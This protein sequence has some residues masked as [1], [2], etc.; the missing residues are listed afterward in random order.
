MEM[1]RY[2]SVVHYVKAMGNGMTQEWTNDRVNA[3]ILEIARK[4]GLNFGTLKEVVLY[5]NRGMSNCEISN[6]CGLNRNTVN[7]YVKFTGEMEEKEIYELLYLIGKLGL[8]VK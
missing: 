8:G 3:R 1:D 6:R 2:R 7:K 4:Y 5:R